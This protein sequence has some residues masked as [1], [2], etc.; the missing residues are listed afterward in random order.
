LPNRFGIKARLFLAF[1]LLAALTAIASAV[2]WWVFSDIDRSVVRV[3]HESVPSM[4]TSLHLAEVSAEIAATAPSIM[5]SNSQETRVREQARLDQRVQ[6]LTVMIANLDASTVDPEIKAK[7]SNTASEIIRALAQLNVAVEQRLY[8]QAQRED[9]VVKLSQAQASLLNLLEPMVDD[10]VFDLVIS[11]EQVTAESNL[12]ITNFV[13]VGV[14][15]LYHLLTIN[16]DGNLAA[17][18][19]AEAN[20]IGNAVLLQPVSERFSAAA[21]SIENN[22]RQ[23]PDSHEKPGLRIAIQA[24]LSFG[25]KSD[26]VFTTRTRL[27]ENANEDFNYLN[28]ERN[29]FG[30][31][32]KS[33]HEL[34][35][36]A[37]NPMID[38]AAFNLV[39][40]TEAVAD[41][42]TGSIR[43]LIDVGVSTLHVLL[44]IRAE[45]NLAAGLLNEAA[46]SSDATQLQPLEERFIAAKGQ[47]T[48]IL[49]SL[50]GAFDSEALGVVL[51]AL[52]DH[53][54]GNDSIFVLRRQELD[55][56]AASQHALETSQALAVTLGNEVAHLVADARSQSDTAALG[57]TRAIE[58][59][60]ILMLVLTVTSL[61]GAIIVV[62]FYVGPRIVQP[63]N[64]ITEA[65]T[66]LADGNTSVE[67]PG[68]ERRDE[69]GRM[70]QSLGVFRDTAIEV[71][72]TNLKEIRATRRRLSD[73]IESISE[74]FSLYGPD[75]CLI[76]CNSKYK[77]LLYPEIAGDI[78][79]GMTFESIVRR[80]A[81][82]GYISNAKGRVEEWLSERLARHREPEGSH[83]QQR[84][85]GRWIMVSERKTDDGGTVAV[86]SDITELKKREAELAE[87]SNVL[88]QL[89]NQL[90]KYLSPQVYDSIFTGRQEVTLT[91]Q[92]KKLTVFFSDI[93]GF[94]ETADKLESEDLTHI[95]F[96]D[97]E[98]R[99]VKEDALACVNMAIAMQKRMHELQAEWR[100]S[101]IE[102]PLVCR[103]GIN[104]GYCTVGNFGSEDRMDYTIIGGGVNL[105][106]RLE[107]AA[108]PG[109]ILISYE[110]YAQVKDQI[111]CEER[112]TIKV[113]GI[114]YP[115]STYQVVDT[116]TN[117]GTTRQVIREDHPN[118][119]LDLDLDAMSSSERNRVAEI[120]QRVLKKIG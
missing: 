2:A 30:V 9:N 83:V 4:V 70:A 111:V 109:E 53:G 55:Q 94:T 41:N 6:A 14:N 92:R 89:S 118:V 38:D 18:L 69:L 54:T 90:S 61:L 115:V 1:G 81:E 42:S 87:K 106:S 32:L 43:D 25:Q 12:S 66:Q 65:M 67:I 101:G 112:D 74:A 78:S 5:A 44:T 10:A 68:R 19:L 104:S 98:T 120:L 82:Q 91:S 13:E 56:A 84:G 22:L 79:P 100:G 34:F 45:G 105:A 37:L 114:A 93:A 27:L 28:V 59:G 24:L 7:I 63:L 72:K 57:S 15:V 51:T 103:I 73:S 29:E 36:T 95:F 107:S 23:L 46:V 97:P 96:G 80:A 35:L 99:G 75:D 86:Y 108:T 58:R 31:A 71:Q 3:T 17:G 76:V 11:G 48:R 47:I 117:L 26:N 102:K 8:L 50:P 85:D 52:I 20:Q 88:E 21:A 33:A 116:F 113:K 40:S 60:Q 64:N 49:R 39:M 62:I 110:T 16:A 77:E 119:K